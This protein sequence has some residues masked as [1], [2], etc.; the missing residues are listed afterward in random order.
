MVSTSM[1]TLQT[2]LA[3]ML[4]TPDMSDVEHVCDEYEGWLQEVKKATNNTD[5]KLMSDMIQHTL[6]AFQSVVTVC[7]MEGQCYS[8]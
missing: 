5:V 3:A 2:S 7:R 6:P 1:R 4:T 8:L